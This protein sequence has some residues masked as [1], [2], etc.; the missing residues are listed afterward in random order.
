[1]MKTPE[2]L[3][4]MQSF[5]QGKPARW[6]FVGPVLPLFAIAF[7]LMSCQQVTDAPASATSSQNQSPIAA[8]DGQTCTGQRDYCLFI[9]SSNNWGS[10]CTRDCENR[11]A[12]CKASGVYRWLSRRSIE[13]LI[14][15]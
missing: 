15:E 8:A 11:L 13:G 1:M 3:D 14:R 7:L 4:F 2:T 12:S 9:C 10:G 6:R 5:S